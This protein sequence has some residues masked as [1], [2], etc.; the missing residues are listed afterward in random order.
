M[1]ERATF[2]NRKEKRLSN[3]LWGGFCCCHFFLSSYGE[4]PSRKNFFPSRKIFF[5]SPKFRI[6]TEMYILVFRAA[7][8]YIISIRLP[9]GNDRL[10]GLPLP[11]FLRL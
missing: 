1:H 11:R 2:F 6:L 8:M 7:K 5:P 10:Q 3:P 4:I 9:K